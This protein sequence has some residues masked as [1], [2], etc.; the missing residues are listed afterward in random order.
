VEDERWTLKKGGQSAVGHS[1]GNLTGYDETSCTSAK[2]RIRTSSSG[3]SPGHVTS[4]FRTGAG[5][6]PGLNARNRRTRLR[7]AGSRAADRYV[8][9]GAVQKLQ[10]PTSYR[11]K[12]KHAVSV[13]RLL[14]AQKRLEACPSQ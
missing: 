12:T 10:L 9:V 13:L 4:S 2:V 5:A 7:G 11:D 8:C 3:E 6:A 14:H 1:T